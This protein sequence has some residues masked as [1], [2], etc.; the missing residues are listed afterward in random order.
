MSFELMPIK[1]KNLVVFWV[2]KP[3][4]VGHLEKDYG[5]G[6]GRGAERNEYKT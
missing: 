5:G 3:R 6:G 1:G 2:K 4:S